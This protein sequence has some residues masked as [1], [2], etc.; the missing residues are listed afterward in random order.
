VER[1]HRDATR[2][3]IGARALEKA[4]RKSLISLGAPC[5]ASGARD[6]HEMQRILIAGRAAQSGLSL[7]PARPPINRS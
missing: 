2:Q 1:R 6:A 5:A 3:V 4:L 7:R